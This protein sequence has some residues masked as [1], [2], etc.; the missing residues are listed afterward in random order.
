MTQNE[1]INKLFITFFLIGIL[2]FPS[3]VQVIHSVEG[4]EH[5]VCSDFS[6]HV[7]ENKTDCELCHFH[8]APFEYRFSAITEGVEIFT[9]TALDSNYQFL[10][11]NF[12]APNT[13]LRGPPVLS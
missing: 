3:A 12:T 10:S 9:I 6:T 2:L 13:P 8:Y 1:K 4:H 5:N 7:H 11:G